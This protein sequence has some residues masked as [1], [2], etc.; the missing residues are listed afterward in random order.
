M[1]LADGSKD[2]VQELTLSSAVTTT[3]ADHSLV[4]YTN[5]IFRFTGRAGQVLT[6]HLEVQQAFGQDGNDVVF[7]IQSRKYIAGSNTMILDGIDKGGVQDWSGTLPASGEYEIYVSNPPVSDHAIQHNIH[8]VLQ[9][10]L[11]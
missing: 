6:A 5:H 9:V 3:S 4:P 7:W 10:A 11:K 2:I 1:C 8:Y